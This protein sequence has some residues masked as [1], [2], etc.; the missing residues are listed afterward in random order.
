MNET[1]GVDSAFQPGAIISDRYEVVGLLGAGSMGTVVRAIDRTLEGEPVALKLLY[2]H[3]VSDSVTFARFRNEVLIAR[4]L[5]H[6]NIV[7]IYDFGKAGAG[8]YF[9]SMEFVSGTSLKTRIYSPRYPELSFDEILRILFEIGSGIA[10]AH[11]HNVVHRD[12]KPDNI[13][14]S[15]RNEIRIT[16]FGLARQLTVDKGFTASGE[17]VG[18]PCYMAPEQIRGEKLDGRADIYSLGILAYEMVTGEKPFDDENW[19]TLANMHLRDELPEFPPHLQV[20]PWFSNLVQTCASKRREDRFPTAEA[21]CDEIRKHIGAGPVTEATNP[22]VF[23]QYLS[24]VT[25][26]NRMRRMKARLLKRSAIFAAMSAII[27]LGVVLPVLIGRQSPAIQ[28]WV[29]GAT[30]T[31]E[32]STGIP[33]ASVRRAFRVNVEADPGKLFAAIEARLPESVALL[34]AAGVDPNVESPDGRRAL[35]IAAATKDATTAAQLIAAGSAV[36]QPDRSGVTPLMVAAESDAGEV[37]AELIS[38]GAQADIADQG[39]RT[40]LMFAAQAGSVSATQQILKARP[41]VHARDDAGAPVI[42]CAALGGSLPVMQM[43]VD[44]GA[45]VND[46]DAQGNTPLLHAVRSKRAD[47]VQYLLSKGA[48][49]TLANRKG[50]TPREVA[51]SEIRKILSGTK[52]QAPIAANTSMIRAAGNEIV[53][54]ASRPDPVAQTRIR[55]VGGPIGKWV[56]GTATKVTNVETTVRNVG[57]S[58]ATQVKIVARIPGGYET[59][60]SGPVTLGPNQ[61]AKYSIEIDTQHQAV[62]DAGEIKI[63]LTCENCRRS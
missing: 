43:L 19:L 42:G 23:S 5:S 48:D 32:R 28:K 55:V 12:L 36:N 13:L 24:Q 49:A 59:V 33:L 60:L 3:L 50:E 35:H 40:A 47:L 57:D 29:L 53:T 54:S 45:K 7:R 63:L 16:D 21:F 6:P 11:R 46:A 17:T 62:P 38:A 10:H 44:A 15:D 20:P 22:A 14:I 8:Y 39:K 27:A 30:T 41:F 18:T 1:T 2:P 26:K 9:L 4:K 37:V 52:V 34:L 31:M 51:N 56:R 58:E 61:T 25:V